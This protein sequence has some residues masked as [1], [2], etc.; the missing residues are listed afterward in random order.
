MN[1]ARPLSIVLLMFGML[2]IVVMLMQDFDL[3]GGKKAIMLLGL[4]VA[5]VGVTWAVE[6][7]GLS[8]RSSSVLLAGLGVVLAVFAALTPSPLS[9]AEALAVVAV[10][11]VPLALRAV[12]VRSL[13]G[14]DRLP[15]ILTALCIALA[16]N[17]CA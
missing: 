11:V 15:A 17:R 2:W 5:T 6:G 10:A 8:A 16:I 13:I 1:V 9:S 3:A 7:K 4:A 14:F 12:G